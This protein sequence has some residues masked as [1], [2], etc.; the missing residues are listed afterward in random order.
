MGLANKRKPHLPKKTTKNHVFPTKRN[1]A[2]SD[3]VAPTPTDP[4]P[5]SP[6]SPPSAHS[7]LSAPSASPTPTS[8]STEAP[9]SSSAPSSPTRLPKKN[10]AVNHVDLT[11]DESPNVTQR[12]K[13]KTLKTRK[14]KISQL[15]EAVGS[16]AIA[17]IKPLGFN[18]GVA[19]WLSDGV[20][21]K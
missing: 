8:Q 7:P 10:K 4:V 13:K 3:P 21:N 1:T 11:G 6:P 18:S 2:P 14:E 9:P 17:E 5:P 16:R 12:K 19:A 15:V 20:N